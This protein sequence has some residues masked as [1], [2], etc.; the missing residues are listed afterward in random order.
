MF[1]SFFGGAYGYY[2]AGKEVKLAEL[3]AKTNCNFAEGFS[4][5]TAQIKMNAQQAQKERGVLFAG[6]EMN[7]QILNKEFF[8]AQEHRNK[9]AQEAQDRIALVQI[10][11]KK[12]GQI[13][14]RI[15]S[16]FQ[17]LNSAQA[18]SFNSNDSWSQQIL[19]FEQNNVT[20]RK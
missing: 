5:L 4:T 12:N 2:N 3:L 16:S 6:V 8:V 7:N 10:N 1:G 14:Q 18:S 13:L 15:D 9:I 20:T 17:G 11:V 19:G